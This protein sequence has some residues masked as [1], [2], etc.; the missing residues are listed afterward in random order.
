MGKDAIFAENTIILQRYVGLRKADIHRVLADNQVEA[1]GI[2][3][4]TE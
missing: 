1:T 2:K 4:N 3:G